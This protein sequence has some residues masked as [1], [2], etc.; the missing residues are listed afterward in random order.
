MKS[1]KL[2]YALDIELCATYDV[3]AFSFGNLN[4]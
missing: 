3:L 2:W 1:V 4:V